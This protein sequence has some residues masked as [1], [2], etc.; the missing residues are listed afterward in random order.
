MKTYCNSLVQVAPDCHVTRSVIPAAKWDKESIPFIE[1]DL[2]SKRP[3]TY[4]QEELIFEVHV[5]RQGI[6]ET[7]LKT[8]RTEIWREL[9]CKS[10]ACMRASSLTKKYGWGVHFNNEGKMAIYPM[11]SE[12]YRQFITD[13]KVKLYNAMK[14]KR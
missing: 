12:G 6:G 13:T 14:S 9:F 8:H 7:E 2:L 5:R 11:E 1:Y 3:Y 4:T 10:H